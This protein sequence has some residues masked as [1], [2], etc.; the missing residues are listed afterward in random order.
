[1]K[2]QV[3]EIKPMIEANTPEQ[4][5]RIAHGQGVFELGEGITWRVIRSDGRTTQHEIVNTITAL[6]MSTTPDD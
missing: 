4:A 6:V 3:T 5:A 1:M 2:Y